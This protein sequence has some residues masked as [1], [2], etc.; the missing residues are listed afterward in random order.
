[1]GKEIKVNW[2]T[3]STS[4]IN[5]V[6][7][8]SM[9]SC[10]LHSYL[11]MTLILCRTFPYICWW[12]RA[13]GGSKHNTRSICAFRR[14]F[15]R[16]AQEFTI[17]ISFIILIEKLK[18]QNL[19]IHKNLRVYTCFLLYYWINLYYLGYCFVSFTNQNV[20]TRTLAMKKMNVLWI[21]FR[22]LKQ[23]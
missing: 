10:M 8:S 5:K 20:S 15:V 19:L 12:S 18:L 21:I 7:T 16:H 9:C 23:Q 11:S 13:R 2:A 4:G 14:N 1:M 3:T 17:R 22:M 6:D